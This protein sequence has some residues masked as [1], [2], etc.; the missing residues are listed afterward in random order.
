MLL[1]DLLRPES[2][3]LDVHARSKKNLLE[4]ASRLLAG[5][6]RD[7]SQRTV[8]AALCDRE[9]LGST[10]LGHGVAIPHGRI[11]LADEVHIALLRL[12]DPI[13]FDALDDAPVDLFIAM[14]V[15][16]HHTDEHVALL[17]QLAELLS[18]PERRQ[19]LRAAT[20]S[21]RLLQTIASWQTSQ[22]EQGRPTSVTKHA[23]GS[24]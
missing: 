24:G 1:T 10:G 23:S 6:E 9:R 14:V 21:K 13:D 8:F 20:G 4:L 22:P 11:E 16:G 2:I 18:A 7:F 19:Q 15:P 17:A 3:A 5:N 12:R